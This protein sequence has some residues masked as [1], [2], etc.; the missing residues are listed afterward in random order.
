M[1][2]KLENNR[3]TPKGL[4][5]MHSCT[6]PSCCNPAHLS[7]G[8]SQEDADYRVACN[9]QAKQKGVTHGRAKLTDDDVREIR[10]LAAKG[11]LQHEIAAKYGVAQSRI[12]LIYNRKTWPHVE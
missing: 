12:S 10:R 2:W 11:V 4:Q 6:N 9:R 1:A 3:K 5:V 7:V 8:T